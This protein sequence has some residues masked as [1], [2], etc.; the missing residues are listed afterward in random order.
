[1]INEEAYQEA[2]KVLEE[3]ENTIALLRNADIHTFQ[4]YPKLV[5]D[6]VTIL[7]EHMDT[8]EERLGIKK[9]AQI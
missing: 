8:I 3:M 2:L 6:C 5:A 4:T 7:H 1:M 9:A